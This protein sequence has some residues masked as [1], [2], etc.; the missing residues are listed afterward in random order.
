MFAPSIRNWWW[1]ALQA[2]H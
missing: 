2:A 1:T